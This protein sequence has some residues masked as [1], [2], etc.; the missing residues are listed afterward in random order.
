[1]NARNRDEYS[2]YFYPVVMGLMTRTLLL[3]H[4]MMGQVNYLEPIRSMGDIRLMYLG[5]TL[6]KPCVLHISRL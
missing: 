6:Q 4:H 3:N 2:L 1:L 5:T